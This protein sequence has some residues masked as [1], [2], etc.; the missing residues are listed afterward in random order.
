[1]ALQSLCYLNVSICVLILL[2]AFFTT[3]VSSVGIPSYDAGVVEDPGR[4]ANIL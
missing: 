2:S 3:L 1:M 4:R